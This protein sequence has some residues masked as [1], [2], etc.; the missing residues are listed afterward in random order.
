M[1][2]G[3]AEEGWPLMAAFVLKDCTIWADQFDL[4]SDTNSVDLD[5]AY[6]EVENTN[7]GSGGNRTF[8]AGLQ[9]SSLDLMTFY[10]MATGTSE[11]V[12]NALKATTGHIFTVTPDGLTGSRA[13]FARALA[14]GMKQTH[15]VGDM[16]RL[17]GGFKTSSAEGFLEGTVLVPKTTA[18][19]TANGTAYQVGAVSSTQTVYAALHVFAG[20]GT[21]P[22]LDVKIQ[23][24]TVGFPSAT[25]RITFAQAT[26]AT[27][28]FKTVAGAITDDYWRVAYTIAGT[29]P[30]F[31]FAVV[32]AIA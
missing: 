19:A 22:T 3:Q 20:S 1:G 8:L 29:G 28:E 21:T 16:A 14:G 4:S 15:K 32:M 27:S 31:S 2:A 9:E 26:G 7:F 10:D 11:P 24:D 12:L 6:D 5:F 17:D 13:L 23:S 25:D 18:T 30:S